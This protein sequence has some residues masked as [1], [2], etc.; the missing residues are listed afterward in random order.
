VWRHI[1]DDNNFTGTA[2]KTQLPLLFPLLLLYDE[3][4]STTI[5]GL[6]LVLLVIRQIKVRL[7]VL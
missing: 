7:V 3:I 1:P 2:T 4:N 5:T 6:S